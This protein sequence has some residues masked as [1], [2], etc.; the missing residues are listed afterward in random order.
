MHRTNSIYGLYV[1]SRHLK[2]SGTKTCFGKRTDLFKNKNRI[3][4]L[5]S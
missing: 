3:D 1:T 5:F 4:Y 2:E